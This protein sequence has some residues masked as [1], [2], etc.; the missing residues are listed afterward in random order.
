M[1]QEVQTIN[2]FHYKYTKIPFLELWANITNVIKLIG[3]DH[4]EIVDFINLLENKNT[5][6]NN[7]DELFNE[8]LS[9]NIFRTNFITF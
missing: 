3:K 4:I 6:L 1:I 5:L 8:L 2:F 9:L 7:H